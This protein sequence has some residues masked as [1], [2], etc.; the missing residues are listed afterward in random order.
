MKKQM[1]TSQRNV[2]ESLSKNEQGVYKSTSGG[3]DVRNLNQN[4]RRFSKSNSLGN[5]TSFVKSKYRNS[6][7]DVK[8]SKSSHDN[9]H[10]SESNVKLPPERFES[11]STVQTERTVS[12][13]K[14]RRHRSTSSKRF[15]EDSSVNLATERTNSAV[16]VTSGMCYTE[17]DSIPDT[18][19][20]HVTQMLSDL[21]DIY[22]SGTSRD[23]PPKR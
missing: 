16:S 13:S 20:E 1:R 7:I 4:S 2:E 12:T 17:L 22:K 21:R 6:S 10:Q 15:T 23:K 18:S 8:T 3:N 11:A 14:V 19:R 5:N 9:R